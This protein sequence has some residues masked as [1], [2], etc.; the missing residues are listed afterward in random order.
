MAYELG[1]SSFHCNDPRLNNCLFGEVTL[2]KN[3]DIDKYGYSGYRTWFDRRSSFSFLGR[4]FGPIV[5]IFGLGMS[6]SAHIDSMKKEKLVF[7][8]G[9]TQ[10]LEHTL[11]AEKM[12]WINFTV[13]KKKVCLSFHYNGANN[14]L[15]VNG[16]DC[17]FWDCSNSLCIGNISKDWSVD[18]WLKDR[19]AVD[20]IKDIH[21]YLIKKNNIA[22]KV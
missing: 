3:S 19:S 18:N 21:H 14:Y 15:L 7:G 6:S 11:T 8:K 10:G 5:L 17:R 9:T 13:T 12:C 1:A 4:G 16:S 22:C 2:T 20:D